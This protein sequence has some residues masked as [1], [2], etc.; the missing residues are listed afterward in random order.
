M[1]I[2]SYI[3]SNKSYK[4]KAEDK[5]STYSSLVDSESKYYN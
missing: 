4:W 1:F 3:Y 5:I 2:E